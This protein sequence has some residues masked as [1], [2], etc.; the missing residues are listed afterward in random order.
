MGDGQRDAGGTLRWRHP[1]ALGA[2]EVRV[3]SIVQKGFGV[4]LG[5][6]GVALRFAEVMRLAKAQQPALIF[7]QDLGGFAERFRGVND[8]LDMLENHLVQAHPPP[9]IRWTSWE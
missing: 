8:A 5:G 2:A 4:V 3:F 6:E 1:R 9:P 7:L